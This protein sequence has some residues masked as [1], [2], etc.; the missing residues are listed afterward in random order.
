MFKNDEVAAFVSSTLSGRDVSASDAAGMRTFTL[1]VAIPSNSGSLHGWSIHRLN[2]PGRYVTYP[3]MAT[4]CVEVTYM[5][6]LGRLTVNFNSDGISVETSNIGAF[7]YRPE[8]LPK[9]VTEVPFLVDG[10]AIEL[11]EATWSQPNFSFGLVQ[12]EGV[13]MVST[14]VCIG[15]ARFVA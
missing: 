3:S 5:H 10:Q 6:R 13:W 9:H 4:T 11:D 1:T 2:I 7:S 15:L 8:S 12:E 14:R